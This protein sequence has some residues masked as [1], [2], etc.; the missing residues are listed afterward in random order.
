MGREGGGR[1]G[2]ARG[3]LLIIKKAQRLR[4]HRC[5]ERYAMLV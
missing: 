1:I 5:I 2:D 4:L 3:D